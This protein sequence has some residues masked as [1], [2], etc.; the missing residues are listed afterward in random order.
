MQPVYRE[1]PRKL[2][3]LQTHHVLKLLFLMGFGK[4]RY[5]RW[6]PKIRAEGTLR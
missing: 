2:T 1:N 3:Q 6:H 5:D 4:F